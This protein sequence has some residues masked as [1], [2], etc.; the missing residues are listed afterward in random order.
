[1]IEEDDD[2]IKA[3]KHLLLTACSLVEACSCIIYHCQVD[4][5]I[6]ESSDITME[7]LEI[8]LKEGCRDSRPPRPRP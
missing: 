3:H 1:M 5:Y 4:G 7:R 2:V 8:I 6:N